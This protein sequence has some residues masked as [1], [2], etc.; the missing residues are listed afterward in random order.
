MSDVE[1]RTGAKIIYYQKLYIRPRSPSDMRFIRY[2]HEGKRQWGLKRGETIHVLEYLSS[3]E[4]SLTDFTN[5]SFRGRIQKLVNRNYV[6]TVSQDAVSVLPPVSTPSKIINVG[7]NYHDHAAEQ[8]EE[9][10][11]RPLLFSKPA[12]AIIGHND[13]ILHPPDINHLD[14]E[15]E[16]AV[17]IGRTAK[18]I[19]ANDVS[20]YIAGYTILNDVSARDAQF[21]DGQFF[22]GK[23][24]DTFAPLGPVLGT[25]DLDMT[26]AEMKLTVNDELKQHSST[27]NLIFSVAE[28]VEFTSNIMTLKPG[29]VI[30]TGTPAGVG[31]FRDPPDLLEE[32]DRVEA[33]IEGIGTLVNTVQNG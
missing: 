15:I 19:S 24:Y 16:L 20:E 12:S 30:G 4:P 17:V 22:R 32:G 13:P 29:D 18:D 6:P 8:N 7:L 33:S 25:T 31:I 21:D 26:D 3:E 9:P 11:E 27:A 2:L 14:Y 28:L 23:G 5:P 10:P 1:E